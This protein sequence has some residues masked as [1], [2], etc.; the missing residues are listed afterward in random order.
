VAPDGDVVVIERSVDT[1][2]RL[3]E[4]STAPDVSYLVGEAQVLP[5]P[6]ESV[7]LVRAAAGPTLEAAE[8]F[9]RILRVGGQVVLRGPARSALNVGERVLR[10]AGF[11]DIAVHSDDGSASLTARKP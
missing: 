9:F 10:E 8:E 11:V 2:E 1:L 5:L 7:D 6:D 3:L 4:T